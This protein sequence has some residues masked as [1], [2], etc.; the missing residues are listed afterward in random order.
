MLP[1]ASIRRRGR[2]AR[3]AGLSLVAACVPFAVLLSA[4]GADS[5]ADL[6]FFEERVR[7]VLVDHCYEC[8][9]A[10]SEKVKGQYLVDTREGARRGGESRLPAIVPGDVAASRFITAIRWS[11]PDLQ[12]PP[13]KRLTEAQVADLVKWVQMGAPDPREGKPAAHTRRAMTYEEA[14]SYW[15]FRPLQ[16]VAVPAVKVGPTAA[17]TGVRTPV[18]AFILSRLEAK[19]LHLSAPTE[20]RKLLRRAAFALTGLPPEPADFEA[21]ERDAAPGALRRAVDRLLAGPH[22]GER[23]GRHWLDVARFAESSGFEHDYDRPGAWHY[24]DFVIRALNDD[25]PYDQFVR[26][27][28]AGDELAPDNPLAL[29]ATGFLG[30]GVFPTQITANEVERVRY[31]ALDDMASTTGAA[32]LG[33]SVGCARCH[34]HKF[35]P[36][37]SRDYYR[38]ISTFTT[39]VRTELDLDLDP[40]GN[41]ARLV[42][43]QK[44]HAGKVA[45]R[46]AFERGALE[47]QFQAWLRDPASKPAMPEWLLLDDAEVTSTAGATLAPQSDGSFLASGKNPDFD[48]YVFKARLPVGGLTALRVEAL[49][50][51]SFTK[52]GPGRADNGNFA[53]SD[54]VVTARPLGASGDA[55][56][57]PLVNSRATFEQKGLPVAAVIDADKKSGWAVDPEFGKDHA[58]VFEFKE[59]VGLADGVELSVTLKFDVNNRHSIGRPRLSVSA[60]PPV[61]GSGGTNAIPRLTSPGLPGGTVAAA[62]QGWSTPAAQRTGAQTAALRQWHR[63]SNAEW[64][65]LNAAVDAV[66]AAKPKPVLSKVLIA[67]EGLPPVRMHTQGADF[68]EKTYQLRRGDV[69][70]KLDPALAGFLPVLSKAAESKWQQAPPSGWRTSYRRRA[71]ASWIT[72]VDDGAG[73]LLARVMVNRVWAQHF[74]RGLV[75]TPNDFGL[76][77]EPPSHPELL[78]WLAG[79]FVRSAWSIKALHRLIL[80]SAVW[81]QSA[82]SPASGGEV[83]A[84]AGHRLDPSN[85]LLWH[86]PRRRL[87][88]EAI[89]DSLLAVAGTLDRHLGGAGTLDESQT[90]RSVYFM[91][92]RSQLTRSLQ[93]FDAPDHVLSAGAR[94]STITAPQALMFLNSPFVRSRASEF[95]RR[96]EPAFRQS[97]AEAVRLGYELAVGRKPTSDELADALRFLEEPG[98]AGVEARR[99]SLVD[100]CQVLFG[101]N[102]FVYVD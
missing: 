49:S 9:S 60:I 99:Q 90:R 66:V 18:D 38:L 14:K 78:E 65:R 55:T 40:D 1:V 22:Y 88:A 5:A 58:A 6:N 100:F 20:P 59:P 39:T 70:Q 73:A 53:L 54:L 68:F 35:D 80:D 36:I 92:K 75:A 67:S 42:G 50:H 47:D 31:D 93:L 19:G 43:W 83:G 44:E 16:P 101:L 48:T 23:W 72:D 27:Q 37:T 51:P 91:I 25:L 84:D 77:G 56:R 86:F 12:M 57:V 10:K 30:A 17:A 2:A 81:Q 62:I 61:A 69:N 87:E 102:E 29:M 76:Q 46:E 34:D 74:G 82:T 28:L 79:E 13:K 96:L 3:H 32:F 71:L 26:W 94:P 11:D 95:A 63:N 4:A 8:H 85:V 64:R 41:A 97:G 52:G 24:R 7:P 89:R 98:A 15:A 45:A 33:L 21:F